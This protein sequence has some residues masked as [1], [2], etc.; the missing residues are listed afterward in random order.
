MVSKRAAQWLLI[1]TLSVWSAACLGLVVT[2]Y[3]PAGAA[4]DGYE[5]LAQM[6]WFLAVGVVWFVFAGLLVWGLLRTRRSN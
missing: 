4:E 1:A 5:A 6:A 3:D 2:R